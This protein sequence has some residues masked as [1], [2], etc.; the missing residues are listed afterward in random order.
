MKP[1]VE[2]VYE[3]KSVRCILTTCA[4]GMEPGIHSTLD[5]VPQNG[6]EPHARHRVVAT[7]KKGKATAKGLAALHKVARVECEPVIAAWLSSLIHHHGEQL[8]GGGA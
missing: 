8:R 3:N 5:L 4:R 2:T 1:I 6:M 7:Q